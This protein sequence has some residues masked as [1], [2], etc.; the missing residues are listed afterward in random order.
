M[1]L[2]TLVPD[3]EVTD[4]PPPTG[5]IQLKMPVGYVTNLNQPIAGADVSP[6][7]GIMTYE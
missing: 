2:S 6:E 5:V 4:T 7:T 1:A 3:G